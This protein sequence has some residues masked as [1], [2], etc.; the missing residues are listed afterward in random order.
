MQAAIY[1]KTDKC[2]GTFHWSVHAVPETVAPAHP[3]RNICAKTDPNADSANAG[4]QR[5]SRHPAEYHAYSQKIAK[6]QSAYRSGPASTARCV[7][8]HA[9]SCRWYQCAPWSAAESA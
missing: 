5:H 6:S 3:A 8:S 9:H 4:Y 2:P 1:L 7:L